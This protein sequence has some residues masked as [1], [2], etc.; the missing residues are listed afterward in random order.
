MKYNSL[1]KSINTACASIMFA[2]ALNGALSVY[3]FLK[4]SAWQTSLERSL[5]TFL[6]FALAE[7]VTDTY[8]TLR[9]KGINRKWR[10]VGFGALVVAWIVYMVGILRLHL[11]LRDSWDVGALNEFLV[12]NWIRVAACSIRFVIVVMHEEDPRVLPAVPQAIPQAEVPDDAFVIE[13]D[14]RDV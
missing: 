2:L 11:R 10:A 9:S 12:W 4:E 8:I 14:Y 5:Y 6:L 3:P 13:D 7:V 1:I